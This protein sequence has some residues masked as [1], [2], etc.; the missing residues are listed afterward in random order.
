ME[1]KAAIMES[2][3]GKRS[4]ME[5]IMEACIEECLEFSTADDPI[6]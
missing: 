5:A 2:N 1:A 6:L 4:P 3:G